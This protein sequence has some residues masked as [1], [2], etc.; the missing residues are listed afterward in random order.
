M[1][2]T[3]TGTA[4]SPG[5]KIL[6]K[7]EAVCLNAGKRLNYPGF[8]TIFTDQSVEPDAKVNFISGVGVIDETG[9]NVHRFFAGQRVVLCGFLAGNVDE[10]VITTV[11][12]MAHLPAD[13]D[14]GFAALGGYVAGI[15]STV[16]KASPSLGQN[17]LVVGDKN[18]TAFYCHVLA[19]IG[20]NTLAVLLEEFVNEQS[21]A[22]RDR[23]MA[24]TGARGADAAILV[25]DKVSG[26][27]I[28]KLGALCHHEGCIVLAGAE[29]IAGG[30]VNT[31]CKIVFANDTGMGAF[32]KG[33]M[34]AQY[35]YPHA[36]IQRTT[37]A[38]LSL[39]LQLIAEKKLMFT[40]GVR[41]LRGSP[42]KLAAVAADCGRLTVM[43]LARE[44]LPAGSQTER[45]AEGSAAAQSSN[46]YSDAA[47]QVPAYIDKI[48]VLF[49]R[50]L[51][52]CLLQATY[53]CGA[54]DAELVRKAVIQAS[55]IIG[56]RIVKVEKPNDGADTQA[57]V[58]CY[59]D[60][61]VVSLHFIGSFYGETHETMEIHGDG[62]TVICRN[63][64]ELAI[65]CKDK[66]SKENIANSSAVPLSSQPAAS[67]DQRFLAELTGS[68]EEA[69]RTLIK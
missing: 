56:Q 57:V 25:V 20:C 4:I 21:S 35:P 1:D 50:R 19:T 53:R 34:T 18:E 63:R 44:A 48:A 8:T 29:G 41:V 2:T 36:Y 55:Y 30:S 23:V 54:I 46:E 6:V 65:H 17:V 68:W 28:T 27:D 14:P 38:N 52:P 49:R 33:Y 42:D 64:T 3:Q 11:S 26:Q 47:L 37:A 40:D 16:Y 69:V 58:I 22:L 24:V 51:N 62:L 61:S 15:I 12:N 5:N 7:L 10:K 67:K 39:A 59:D 60:G 66:V 45:V 31:A 9:T 13:L 32:D 43:L